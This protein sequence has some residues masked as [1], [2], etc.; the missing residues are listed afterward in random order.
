MAV[1][2]ENGTALTLAHECELHFLSATL[3]LQLDPTLRKNLTGSMY[4]TYDG[5]P[6]WI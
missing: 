3:Y 6:M 5:F 4:T 2:F 1:L